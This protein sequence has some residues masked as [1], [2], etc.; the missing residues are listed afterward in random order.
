MPGS[1]GQNVRTSPDTHT[2]FSLSQGFLLR[3]EHELNDCMR[4]VSELTSED[5]SPLFAILDDT[6][7]K[8]PAATQFAMSRK[9]ASSLDFEDDFEIIDVPP[10]V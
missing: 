3:D 2:L 6:A 5:R 7:R 8:R 4:L 10:N 9:E 1:F